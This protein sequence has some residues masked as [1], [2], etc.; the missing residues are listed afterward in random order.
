MTERVALAD[1]T[2]SSVD[3]QLR[4]FALGGLPC[5]V[6]SV[7]LGVVM[8]GVAFGTLPQYSPVAI[9]WYNVNR[10]THCNAFLARRICPSDFECLSFRV[11]RGI[12][13]D[14]KLT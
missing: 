13:G 9:P 12:A 3:E 10:F 8:R 7:G 6:N 4:S 5:G 11:S 14:R 1:L 2:V